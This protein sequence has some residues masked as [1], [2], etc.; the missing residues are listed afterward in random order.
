MPSGFGM[1]MLPYDD[2]VLLV[3]NDNHALSTSVVWR[4]P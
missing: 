2:R 1:F 3:A 4:R